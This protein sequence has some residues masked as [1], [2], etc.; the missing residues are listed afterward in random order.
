MI[1]TLF[2][3]YIT[4]KKGILSVAVTVRSIANGLTA[5]SRVNVDRAKEVGNKILKNMIGKAV[6]THS[7]KRSEQAAT[8]GVKNSIKA[9]NDHIQV[10]P[11]APCFTVVCKI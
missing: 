4:S 7:F 2:A 8:L 10:D 6:L 5:E 3:S 9:D 1:K 11:H